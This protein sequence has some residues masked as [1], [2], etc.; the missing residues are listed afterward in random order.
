M[1]K[2]CSACHSC[3]STARGNKMM[4]CLSSCKVARNGTVPIILIIFWLSFTCYKYL[5]SEKPRD[6]SFPV[7]ITNNLWSKCWCV[8]KIWRNQG[9][10]CCIFL[11]SILILVKH[12]AICSVI[13]LTVKFYCFV[14]V[15]EWQETLRLAFNLINQLFLTLFLLKVWKKHKRSIFL[16]YVKCY[17][18]KH[19]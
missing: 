10:F 4:C 13:C 14:K 15:S 18:S 12:K 2:S 5:N 3:P 19:I 1:L 9:I 16:M 17:I 11:T 7:S 6:N 8:I